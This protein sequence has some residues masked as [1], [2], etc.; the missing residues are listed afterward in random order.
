MQRLT[1]ILLI[2]FILLALVVVI[3]RRSNSPDDEQVSTTPTETSYLVDISIQDVNQIQL[4]SSTGQVVELVRNDTGL[5][6]L[7]DP[8]VEAT[9][10]AL[11]EQ[12]ITNILDMTTLAVI[13]PEVGLAEFGLDNPQ[14][15]LHLYIVGDKEKI[16]SIGDQTPIKNGY[17]VR[18]DSSSPVVVNTSDIEAVLDTF[19]NPPILVTPTPV[20]YP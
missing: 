7:V 17:Y 14:Y 2:G 12:F 1:W 16:I 11:A 15:E 6:N 18:V 8:P 5:W 19:K 9:D 13:S 3:L 4:R 10:E 20:P